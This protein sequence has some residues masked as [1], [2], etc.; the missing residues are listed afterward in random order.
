MYIRYMNGL[1]QGL[2]PDE[3]LTATRGNKNFI[4]YDVSKFLPNM[5][6][7]FKDIRN[8][9][10]V[11]TNTTNDLKTLRL[12]KEKELGRKLTIE[13]ILELKKGL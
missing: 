4:G 9:L 11:N 5:N 7:V 12:Q 3:M 10:N 13:E 6:D 8:N 2:K 1:S